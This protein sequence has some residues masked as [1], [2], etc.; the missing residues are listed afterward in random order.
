MDESTAR[1]AL[2]LDASQM[3]DWS[4]D[5]VSDLVTLSPRA[6]EIFGLPRGERIT[7]TRMRD[8]L[9]EED[10]ERARLAVEASIAQRA[11]YAIEYRV[12]ERWVAARG[13]AMYGDDGTVTGMIGVVQDVTSLKHAEQS[14]RE[15]ALVLQKIN[16]LSQLISAELDLKKLVQAVTDTCTEL[17]GARFGAFFYNVV[18]ARGQA[19]TLYTISGV[20]PDHFS[21]FPMPRATALFGPTFRG[22]GVVRID[23]VHKDPRFGRNEPY[24]GMP[25]GHLP[26]VSY[27]AVPV[28]SRTGKVL[29]GLF[30]GHPDA[31]VFT[32]RSERIIAGLAAQAAIAM[33][34]ASLY[35]TAERLRREA[36]EANRLKDEFLATISHELRTPLHAILGW[37]QILGASP[38]NSEARARGIETIERNAK[39]QQKI[40]E[41]V[42]DVSRIVTGKVRINLDPVDLCTV[43]SGAL[44]TVRPAAQAKNLRL[45]SI[46]DSKSCVVLGDMARL[47]QVAWNLLSNAIKF[48]SKGGRVKLSLTRVNSHVEMVVEDSGEGIAPEFLPHV[49]DRFSQADAS[50]SRAHG[51]LGLGLSIVRHLVDLHG[52]TV[53]ARSEGK[54]KGATFIVHLP[55]ASARGSTAGHAEPEAPASIPADAAALRGIAVLVVDDEPDARDLLQHVLTSAGASEVRLAG[56][57]DEAQEILAR[58]QPNVIV[59]DIGMP[60]TDGYQFMRS[61]RSA[62]SPSRLIPAAALT[63]YARPEDRVKCLSAGFQAHV[64]KPVD[65][66]ELAAVFV[67]LASTQ[68]RN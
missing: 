15:Q 11:P 3:G 55:V 12:S 56:S 37:A 41:D 54:G 50:A 48:T 43:V 44:D 13:R 33:D 51:G 2:A 63:A 23:N 39:L 22:E 35:E 19:Y 62:K 1:L 28:V 52:G 16:E 53:E 67:S 30:F 24:S 49:F 21:R 60:G 26:V 58:W 25:P 57:A 36:E 46:L 65:P 40:I 29:G 4:W 5:A 31:G 32:E 27:L 47:Q 45:Q 61:L 34:N 8:L 68:V 64:V 66:R 38:I 42:L 17:A 7:W 9:H 59:S 14:H 6:S 20:S 10:R 18:D